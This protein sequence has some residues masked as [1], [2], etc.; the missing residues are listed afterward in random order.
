[1]K[2]SVPLS[3]G[4]DLIGEEKSEEEMSTSGDLG[5]LPCEILQQRLLWW[6]VTFA[7]LQLCNTDF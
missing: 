7:A 5:A 2:A 3:T 6:C 1:M 4:C